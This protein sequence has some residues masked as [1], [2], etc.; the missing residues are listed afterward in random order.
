MKYPIYKK[1][2]ALS[3][4][5]CI[6]DIKSMNCVQTLQK[7]HIKVYAVGLV[8][9]KGTIQKNLKLD[10]ST[11]EEFAEALGVVSKKLDEMADH[12]NLQ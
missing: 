4:F 11:E 12:P 8:E 10:D 9:N 5:Y 3:E 6:L 2:R 1:N 7:D